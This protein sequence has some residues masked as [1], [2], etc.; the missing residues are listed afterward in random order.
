MGV[1]WFDLRQK[2]ER[3]P[4][5]STL[6]GLPGELTLAVDMVVLVKERWLALETRPERQA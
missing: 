6:L 4:V 2:S 5:I 3:L 1:R